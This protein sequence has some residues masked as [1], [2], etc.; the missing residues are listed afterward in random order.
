MNSERPVKASIQQGL[1]SSSV[2]QRVI[3]GGEGRTAKL[4]AMSKYSFTFSS[5]QVGTVGAGQLGQS[6]PISLLDLQPVHIP[7]CQEA[8]LWTT[9]D[10]SGVWHSFLF[11]S[12]TTLCCTKAL[13]R[14]RWSQPSKSGN[15]LPQPMQRTELQG[16]AQLVILVFR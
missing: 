1:Y 13:P 16:V 5:C 10:L 4:Q 7:G 12:P 9:E 6:T 3:P 14:G 8:Q 15:L 11:P 2:S